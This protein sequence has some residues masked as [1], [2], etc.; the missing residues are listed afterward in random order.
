MNAYEF[1]VLEQFLH[2]RQRFPINCQECVFDHLKSIY[3]A[4]NWY[5]LTYEEHLYY[6]DLQSMAEEATSEQTY[7][8]LMPAIDEKT[9]KIKLTPIRHSSDGEGVVVPLPT[10]EVISMV[11]RERNIRHKNVEVKEQLKTKNLSNEPL[12][13]PKSTKQEPILYSD[14]VSDVAGD[15]TVNLS[16]CKNKDASE[17]DISN[18]DI[19]II[20]AEKEFEITQSSVIL[21]TDNTQNSV[22]STFRQEYECDPSKNCM[23]NNESQNQLLSTLDMRMENIFFESSVVHVLEDP[24]H[25]KHN[26]CD[27]VITDMILETEAPCI[28]NICE[29]NSI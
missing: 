18:Q 20:Y 10:A 15:C 2:I 9:K 7:C 13:D 19:P 29:Q 14:N 5:L 28:D 3:C 12:T 25:T 17:L 6:Y 11:W 22:T 16:I 4:Y 23:D 26:A 27:D 24:H 1:Y 21:S 8:A